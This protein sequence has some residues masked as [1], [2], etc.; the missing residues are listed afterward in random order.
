MLPDFRDVRLD[1][2]SKEVS[3]RVSEQASKQANRQAGR[4]AGRQANRP[5]M[6][7]ASTVSEGLLPHLPLLTMPLL[8]FAPPHLKTQREAQR[9]KQH[10]TRASVHILI[11]PQAK[12]RGS[13]PT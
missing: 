8:I 10:S 11:H 9:T 3:Q 4:H 6:T 13:A 5:S 12:R 7:E 1:K 2:A